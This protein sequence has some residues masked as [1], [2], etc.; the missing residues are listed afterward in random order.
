[1]K[2]YTSNSFRLQ[3]K[4]QN[5]DTKFLLNAFCPVGVSSYQLS[6]SS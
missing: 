1:M 4:F 2:D 6:V 3:V 5:S